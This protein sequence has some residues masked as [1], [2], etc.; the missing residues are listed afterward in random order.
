MIE[1]LRFAI[2]SVRRSPGFALIAV[3]VLAGAIGIN[4]AVLGIADAVLFR[5]LPYDAPNRLF[6][7]HMVD[8]AT[9]L[10]A[11]FVPRALL[12]TL[13]ADA[14][15]FV[16]F[17]TIDARTD[18]S[19]VTSAGADTLT[20]VGVSA[21]FFELLGVRAARGRLLRSDDVFGAPDAAVLSY[22]A[23]QHRFGSSPSGVG[24]T[25]QVGTTSV[26]VVGVLPPT[27]CGPWS[28]RRPPT[29]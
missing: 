22:G 27:S 7:L 12:E 19:V 16:A 2:R 14:D 15:G 21:N 18:R 24:T 17:A 11:V 6:V 9:G 26:E 1:D 4:A 3:G 8:Q 29:S 28:C 10:P 23:W 13:A 25:L 5:P 20:L